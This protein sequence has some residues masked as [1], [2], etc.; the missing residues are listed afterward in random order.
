MD[1]RDVGRARDRAAGVEIDYAAIATLRSALRRFDHATSE[2]TRRHGLTARRYELLVMVAGA[3]DG[4]RS[5]TISELAERLYLALHTVTELVG[6]AESAGL[7]VRSA[8]TADRR[9]TRVRLTPEGEARLAAA[10]SALKPERERLAR[11]L[12]EIYRRARALAASAGA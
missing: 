5:A 9:V 8:D 11:M 12:G 6:R 3:H 4:T 7:V 1:F 10:A 2:L